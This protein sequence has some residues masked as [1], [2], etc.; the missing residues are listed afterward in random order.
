MTNTS[1]HH[2]MAEPKGSSA[3]DSPHRKVPSLHHPGLYTC[4]GPPPQAMRARL[5]G[6]PVLNPG[7]LPSAPMSHNSLGRCGT[8]RKLRPTNLTQSSTGNRVLVALSSQ[9]PAAWTFCLHGSRNGCS[10]KLGSRECPQQYLNPPG[11]KQGQ[12]RALCAEQAV[13]SLVRP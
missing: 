1:S 9:I 10:S 5:N 7:C 8:Q 3:V 13:T 2:S 11:T 4:P 12:E 6:M